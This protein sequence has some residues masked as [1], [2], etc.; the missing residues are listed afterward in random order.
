[1]MRKFS[2][3]REDSL[4]KEQRDI[5]ID[6]IKGLGISL[7]VFR[8]TEAP[9]SEFVLLFHM[10][11]F[12]IV[13][14]Y[15]MNTDKLTDVKSLCRYGFRK[16]KSLWLPYFLYMSIFS[17][18]HNIFISLNV[19]TNN[20]L[21]LEE[22]TGRYAVLT[23]YRSADETL[24]AIINCGLFRGNA[25]IGGAFWFFY[26]L[27]LLTTGY[28][29][30]EYVLRKIIKDYKWVRVSQ[31]IVSILFLLIGYY[32]HLT[33]KSVYGLNR[34]FSFY[35][36]LYL[37]QLFKWKIRVIIDR[38]NPVIMVVVCFI[39]LLV[40]KPF[41]YIDLAGNNIENPIY[42]LLVSIAGW[43]LMYSIAEI[44]TKSDFSGNHIIT[45]ISRRSVAIIGLHFLAFKL[46]SFIAVEIYGMEKYMIA[47]FP[48]LVHGWW[49]V[50][51]MAV[52]VAVPLLADKVYLVCKGKFAN[53]IVVRRK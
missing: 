31:G 38:F 16:I 14:G 3:R 34:F 2:A 51:Y 29:V 42:F 24:K 11:I 36:L 20:P 32:L 46:V 43:F 19:Y 13:S 49:W 47:V 8:H 30:V 15:L 52:G 44:L 48:V 35:C 39:I 12:F 40:V 7:M 9:C 10:A 53:I 26:A 17:I 22:Y 33:E 4:L 45:Y 21:Y 18:L 37:G 23:N 27:F 25:Q 6:M 28:A 50:A 5:T 41:G 1:M